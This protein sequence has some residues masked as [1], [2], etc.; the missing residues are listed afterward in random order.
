MAINWPVS[1]WPYFAWS[2]LAAPPVPHFFG[3]SE[4]T[5]DRRSFPAGNAGCR[6]QRRIPEGKVVGP[7]HY[8]SYVDRFKELRAKMIR[9]KVV[10][11]KVKCPN[12]RLFEIYRV[13]RV[14]G[15]E[16]SCGDILDPPWS[17]PIVPRSGKFMRLFSVLGVCHKPVAC[18]ASASNGDDFYHRHRPSEKFLV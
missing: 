4:I 5:G 6:N 18:M 14:K 16:P 7:H 8:F 15:M 17:N 12:P 2:A 9:L 13:Y 10:S 3:V 1:L 11:F